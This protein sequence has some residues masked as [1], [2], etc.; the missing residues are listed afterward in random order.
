[1]KPRESPIRELMLK[2]IAKQG[3]EVVANP[4]KTNWKKVRLEKRYNRISSK[5][6]EEQEALKD[7][8]QVNGIDAMRHA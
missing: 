2:D 5:M 7:F 6:L 3:T 8:V 4:L 1:V